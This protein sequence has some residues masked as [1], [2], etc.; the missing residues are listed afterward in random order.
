MRHYLVHLCLATFVFVALLAGFNWLVDSYRIF[1]K[2]DE[3]EFFE[4][5]TRFQKTKYFTENCQAYNSII[6]GNSRAQ[7]FP[8]EAVNSEKNRFFNFAASD[9][10]VNGFFLKAV[11]WMILQFGPNVQY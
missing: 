5:N 8:P 4:S 1:S 10:R 9:D 7:V 6:F 3:K 2:P 11:T